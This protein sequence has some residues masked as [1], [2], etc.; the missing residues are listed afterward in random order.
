MGLLRRRRPEPAAGPAPDPALLELAGA[1][2]R[3]GFVDRADAVEMVRDRSGR[4][5]SDPGPAAAVDRA[6]HDRTMEQQTWSGPGDHDRLGAA[7]AHLGR[8]GVVARMNFTCCQNC[9]TDE[10]DDERTPDPGGG[11]YPWREWAYT[12]FHQQD[13]ERLGDVPAVLFLS[14]SAFRASP[15][16]DPAL[17]QAARAGD[18]EARRRVRVAT[19]SEVGTIVATALR[20]HGLTVEWDGDPD[21]RIRVVV[22]DWRKP[23]PS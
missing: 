13:A 8:Q 16:L 1:I 6:W 12:F 2:I 9:G 21:Q 10:I 7:F 14:Y 17:L 5:E 4:G 18:E 23:L 22:T 11:Q 15:R 3:P 19:D 20:D